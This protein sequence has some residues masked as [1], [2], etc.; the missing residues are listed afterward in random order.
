MPPKRR[1]RTCRNPA[2]GVTLSQYL[3]SY[4]HTLTEDATG[5]T[6]TLS[7]QAGSLP[8]SQQLV[9]LPSL[10][11]A[12]YTD[13]PDPAEPSQR[14]AFGTSG[15]RGSSLSLTFNEAHI[16]AV[17]Q[18]VCDI[19][20]QD[21]N[22]GP[23]F[24]GM[25][26][27]AL[28]EAAYRTALEVLIGNG[29]TVGIEAETPYTPTP[30]ISHAILCWNKR[31]AARADGVVITPSHNPPSD[32]G[33]K[34][35]PPT[36]GPADTQ[37]TSRIE[38]RANELLACGNKDVRRVSLHAARSSALIRPLPLRRAYVEDLGHV[39]NMKVIAASGLRLGADPLGGATLDYWDLIA[40]HYGLQIT[41][42]SR[43][44]D[45]TFRFVPLDH[46]GKIRMDCS[47]PYAMSGLLK[48]REAFDLAFGCDP[49]SDR[50]GIVT[51]HGLMNPNHY[52]SAAAWHLFTNRPEWS[53]KAGIGK[54]LV[55]SSMLDRVAASLNRPLLEVPV[56]F[57]WFVPYFFDGSCGIGCEE[58]AGASFLRLD[59]T[60]W[61]TDKDGPLLCL[62]AAEMTAV[63][64]RTPDALY[65][66]LTE[67]FGTPAYARIDS[68]ITAE[69]RARFAHVTPESLALQTLAG[70]PVTAVLTRAPANNASIGGFKVI[71]E[72]GWF[73]ARPSGTEPICKVYT[74]SFLGETHRQRIETEA[75]D[76]LDRLLR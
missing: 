42:V 28:S 10:L 37:T 35:N 17:T 2:S 63:H 24:V 19:R 33:Y 64:D 60:P 68:P 62:L 40:E 14:I 3:L 36:G 12:Y 5:G 39:L 45:S 66:Q 71:T 56:G 59:G 23:I 25:D 49:D 72:Q 18:A 6:M 13:S 30:V 54:T 74:E 73:A 16:L 29:V 50:H 52:L 53:G 41:V 15:H 7:P 46:D 43:E 21:G 67:R 11:T 31:N 69:K 75:V 20:K 38:K 70:E 55:T 26:T 44:A 4:S 1:N 76:I 51:P 8:T 47:S 48:H 9:H 57:K 34:Y 65:A 32:G 27:H 22:T 58:S 61:S